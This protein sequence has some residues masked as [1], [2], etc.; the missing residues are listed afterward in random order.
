MVDPGGVGPIRHRGRGPD[1]RGLETVRQAPVC[2]GRPGRGLPFSRDVGDTP[3]GTVRTLRRTMGRN[4][5]PSSR[6]GDP[7][8]GG[9]VAPGPPMADSLGIASPLTLTRSVLLRAGD[10]HAGPGDGH[11]HRPVA[12]RM[13]T[14]APSP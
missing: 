12:P 10:D 2:Q 13:G 1:R 4:P 11:H 6:C 9:P 3:G 14:G 7:D 5:L 8:G